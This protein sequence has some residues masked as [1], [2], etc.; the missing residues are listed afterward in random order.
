MF[1]VKNGFRIKQVM[2]GLRLVMLS[3]FFLTLVIDTA[4]SQEPRNYVLVHGSW[5]GEWYWAPIVKG[6]EEHG[7]SAYAISLKGHGKRISEGGP[8]VT[9][10]DHIQDIVTVVED[11]DLSQIILVSHSYGGKP[12]TGAWDRLRDRISNVVYIEAV[13]PIDDDPVAIRPDTRSLKVVM[14]L[15][16]D[17]ADKGMIPVGP[18]IREEDGKLLAPQSFKSAYGKVELKNGILPKTP[19][20]YI[21]AKDSSAK[22]FRKFAD[23]MH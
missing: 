8:E 4:N 7:H 22:V 20:T 19:G 15:Y 11:N 10:E 2:V 9:I 3:A 17:W 14:T 12:A 21:V 6:L 13:T 5:V 1:A 16:P 23:H 18:H